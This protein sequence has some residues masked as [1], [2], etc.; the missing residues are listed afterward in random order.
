MLCNGLRGRKTVDVCDFRR[1]S[2]I[3]LAAGLLRR[4]TLSP[5]H[6]H[7]TSTMVDVGSNITCF[8]ALE[9]LCSPACATF[10][11]CKGEYDVFSNETSFVCSAETRGKAFQHVFIRQPLQA[12]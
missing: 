5:H 3:G 10:T 12:S 1:Q 6:T 11:Y 7:Q 2:L 8:R 9:E 4:P